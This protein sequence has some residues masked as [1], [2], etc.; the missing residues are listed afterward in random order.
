MCIRDREKC[1]QKIDEST[2]NKIV[3]EL[4][5]GGKDI[6][7]ANIKLALEGD[8]KEKYSDKFIRLILN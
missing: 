8:S 4:K 3:E 6:T 5:K 2:A 7:E 1:M